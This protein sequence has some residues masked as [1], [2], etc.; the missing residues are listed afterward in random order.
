MVLFPIRTDRP[1]RTTPYVNYALI[2]L[3]V[4]VFLGTFAQ[5]DQ[6]DAAWH[7]MR[8][9]PASQFLERFP[10]LGYY[11]WP[12]EMTRLY[13]FLTSQFLHADL[14][15]LLGNMVFLWVFGNNVEDRLGKFGYLA[16][17]L[18]CGVFAGLGHW[19]TS[20]SPALGASGA[21][22]GVT[23]AFFAFFP[24]TRI[25]VFFW[26]FLF[27]HFFEL[28]A[29][30]VVL[31]FFL[32]DVFLYTTGHSGVAYTAHLS[33]TVAGFGFGLALL[34]T[35][36]LP[37]EP[38]DL[39]TLLEHRR[40]RE[41]FRKLNREGY[42]AWEGKSGGKSGKESGGEAPQ[43][44]VVQEARRAIAQAM[45]AHDLPQAASL[46][47]E[48]LRR[49]PDQVLSERL[50]TEIAH[51]LFSDGQHASAACVYDLLLSTYPK[52]PDKPG[53]QLMLGLLYAN[54]LDRPS[55]ARPLLEQASQRLTG[56]AKA[57]AQQILDS[58]H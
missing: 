39:L 22:A 52:H 32:K 42:Q 26:L 15:H 9:F 5:I 38:Y 37:R 29:T 17:Y 8:D 54:Y 41:K 46:Y 13:Q 12:G 49:Y 27:I 21:V 23:G 34:L 35:R 45:E 51:Q 36:L 6:A 3:N 4:V 53:L 48:L 18:A 1:M 7:M 24:R 2:T 47:T 50:Q 28:Q 44:S 20:A 56:D 40:R 19:L 30:V 43:D 57:Q 25:T 16:F 11:L 14:F 33:G 10:V 58:I 55:D 31:F